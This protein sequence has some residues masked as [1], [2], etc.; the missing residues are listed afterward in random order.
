VEDW[1]NDTI[2]SFLR[3]LGTFKKTVE[4]FNN[5]R[6][7]DENTSAEYKIV[8]RDKSGKETVRV[9]DKADYSEEA[10]LML[11]EVSRVVDEYNHSVTENEKRQVLMEILERLCGKE[12]YDG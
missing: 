3:D 12:G 7:G 10:E 6:Q 4:D 9:F 2:V 1:T 8:F 5:R 11:G